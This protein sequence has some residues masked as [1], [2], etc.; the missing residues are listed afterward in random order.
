MYLRVANLIGSYLSYHW[1]TGRRYFY[2]RAALGTQ[3]FRGAVHVPLVA[4]RVLAAQGVAHLVGLA[5]CILKAIFTLACLNAI[6]CFSV[7]FT[8]PA[9]GMGRRAAMTRG[10]ESSTAPTSA[11]RRSGP[12][13]VVD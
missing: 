10:V 6:V 9:I 2:L 5:L 3:L 7:L 13:S 12:T 4:C 11:R 1:I 8:G